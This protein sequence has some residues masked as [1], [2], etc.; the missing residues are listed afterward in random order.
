MNPH[1]V[2]TFCNQE[3]PPFIGLGFE[4]F[5]PKHAEDVGKALLEFSKK[6]NP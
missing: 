3:K 2:C 1:P 4:I 5:C 6:A